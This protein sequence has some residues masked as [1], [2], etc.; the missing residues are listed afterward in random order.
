M[1]KKMIFSFFN[2]PVWPATILRKHQDT[3]F[4]SGFGG[5]VAHRKRVK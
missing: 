2:T 5:C 1:G 4:V 3:I